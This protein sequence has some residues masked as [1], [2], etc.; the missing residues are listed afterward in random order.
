MAVAGEQPHAASTHC[1]KRTS[2]IFDALIF[3]AENRQKH[4]LGA[5]LGALAMW[6][7]VEPTPGSLHQTAMTPT[8]PK[9]TFGEMRPPSAMC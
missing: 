5:V 1:S 4:D 9:I 8:P 2:R 6:V 7:R 3:L